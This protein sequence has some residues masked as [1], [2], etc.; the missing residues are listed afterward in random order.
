MKMSR[1]VFYCARITRETIP[2]EDDIM[3][4]TFISPLLTKEQKSSS[5]VRV[6]F[7][8]AYVLENSNDAELCSSMITR[9]K[10]ALKE[11]R[12]STQILTLSGF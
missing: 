10:G 12:A 8:E 6:K 3:K 4:H 11:F 5:Q 2:E 1:N 7:I 9:M